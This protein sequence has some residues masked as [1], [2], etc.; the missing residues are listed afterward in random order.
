MYTIFDEEKNNQILEREAKAIQ[1]GIEPEV[2]YLV[3]KDAN[4]RFEA[5][6]T[7][8]PTGNTMTDLSIFS[9]GGHDL[10]CLDGPDTTKSL[11]HPAILDWALSEYLKFKALHG[12]MNDFQ[13]DV[14]YYLLANAAKAI[15][16]DRVKYLLMFQNIIASS[17]N[18]GTYN[19][20][21]KAPLSSADIYSTGTDVNPINLQHYNRV[22]YVDPNKVPDEY[23]D[24]IVYLQCAY[25]YTNPRGKKD[26]SPLAIHVIKD[27]NHDAEILLRGTPS[28]KKINGIA[29]DV[30]CIICNEN[31][32]FTKSIEPEWLNYN[33]YTSR[34]RSVYIGNWQNFTGKET[35]IPVLEEED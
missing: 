33:Y 19:F 30:P 31:L 17:P 24:Q 7:D 29:Q 11:D 23:K 2:C 27:L 1:V 14:V 16:K 13:D 12:A 25:M 6:L 21:T 10:A 15:F 8:K 26:A 32:E 34:V 5:K 18:V 20:A 28:I 22:F 35:E 9:S 4:N 3:S